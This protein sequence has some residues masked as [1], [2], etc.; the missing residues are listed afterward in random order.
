MSDAFA[1]ALRQA[2][3]AERHRAGLSQAKLAEAMGWSRQVVSAVETG[4]RE[5]MA[6]ELPALC[7][8]LGVTLRQ[9]LDRVPQADWDDLRL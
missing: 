2:V 9:L 8:A 1:L 4:T 5:V 7:A 3:R 6:R